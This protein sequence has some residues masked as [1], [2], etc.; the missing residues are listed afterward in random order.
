VIGKTKIYHGG[1][2]T[3]RTAKDGNSKTF[4]TEVTEEHKGKQKPFTT[5]DTHSTREARS[6]QATERGGGS[7]KAKP[8]KHGGTEEAEE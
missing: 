1:T 2:E 7:E 8:L 5:K 4:T 6:G 3:R